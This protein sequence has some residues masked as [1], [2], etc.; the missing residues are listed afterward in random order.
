MLVSSQDTEQ[1]AYDTILSFLFY[2]SII[3][4]QLRARVPAGP[5]AA[6]EVQQVVTKVALSRN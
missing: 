3:C 6:S 2:E 5:A 1:I 4:S